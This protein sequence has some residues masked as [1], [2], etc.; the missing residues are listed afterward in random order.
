MNSDITKEDIL[1]AIHAVEHPEINATLFELGMLKD[2]DI[3]P[4]NQQIS[5][6][7]AL[8]MLGIPQIVKEMLI[9]SLNQAAQG[10]GVKLNYEVAEMNLV[11]RQSFM[12]KAQRLWRG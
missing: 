1:K 11:E 4:D 5:L 8:P 10:V 12:E 3:S 7:L 6:T 9:N 2:V